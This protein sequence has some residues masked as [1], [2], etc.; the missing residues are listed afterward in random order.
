MHEGT[1]VFHYISHQVCDDHFVIFYFKRLK[2]II[3]TSFSN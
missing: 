2:N 3:V 1:L